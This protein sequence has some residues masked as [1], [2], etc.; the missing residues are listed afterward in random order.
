MQKDLI[1]KHGYNNYYR[2]FWYNF[3]N[4]DGMTTGFYDTESKAKEAIECDRF[5]DKSKLISVD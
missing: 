1:T 5:K 4:I 2:C 3:N